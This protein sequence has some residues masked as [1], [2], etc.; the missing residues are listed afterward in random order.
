MM[1]EQNAKLLPLAASTWS[2][3][4]T[5]PEQASTRCVTGTQPDGFAGQW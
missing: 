1:S 3:A 2:R 5:G 4:S